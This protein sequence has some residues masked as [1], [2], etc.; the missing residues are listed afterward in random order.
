MKFILHS[1]VDAASIRNSLGKPEYSYYFVLK[2]F[3][4]VLEQLGPVELVRNPAEEVDPIFEAAVARGEDCVF[5]SVSPPNTVTLGL[6]CP[7]IVVVA[8]EFSTIPD[9]GWDPG[10]PREDWRYVFGRLGYAISLSNHTAHVVKLAMGGDFPIFA[11]ASPV[12][13]RIRKLPVP[14]SGG[15]IEECEIAI[16]GTVFDSRDF[17]LAPEQILQPIFPPPPIRPT[18]W[19]IAQAERERAEEA[20]RERAEA[21]H[22]AALAAAAAFRGTLRYRLAVTKR[23]LLEWYREAVR[24][25]LPS[26]LVRGIARIGGAVETAYRRLTG[27]K[28]PPP[29]PPPPA[30]PVVPEIRVSLGGVV[31]TSMLNPT[32]GRKN[33]HDLLTAFLWVFRDVEDATLVLKIVKG[34]PHAYRRDLFLILAR[35]GP[36]KCRVVTMD[37]FLEDAD[38]AA[39]MGA[40][41]FY[42]NTS[43]AEGMCMPLMEFMSAGKPVIAPCHTAMADYI[44]PSAAFVVESTPEHNVWPNDPR[45]L[46]TTM[47]EKLKWDTV[48][49][50]FEQSYRVAKHAPERYAEMG[51]NADR[52]MRDYCSDDAVRER[53]RHI[54]GQVVTGRHDNAVQSAPRVAETETT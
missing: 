41:S 40:T 42:V 35:S 29:P 51:A 21:E 5:I 27:W 39:L 32:D 43:N 8:W 28:P 13:D 53:L 49:A 11:V 4:P 14:P 2:A 24:D 15:V 25:L 26:V 48:A 12:Y 54:M 6:K 44:D 47:R 22:Q 20:A 45:P 10:N 9:G 38:Y 1:D 33:W 50:A 52:I 16:R 46:Y 3:Q 19:E 17:E 23:Y 36:F 37:G 7:T 18:A 31:Y 30:P 34:D